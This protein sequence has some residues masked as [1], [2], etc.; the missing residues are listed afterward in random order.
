MLSHFSFPLALAQLYSGDHL[1]A[2]K[3]VEQLFRKSFTTL[4]DLVRPLTLG[5]GQKYANS[6]Y[7]S[8][9]ACQRCT[10]ICPVVR[11]FDNPAEALGMLPHQIIFSL[12]IGKID[13]AMGAQMI[14]SCSTC[15][16][17]QEHC[18]NQ[19]ELCDIFY[20]L[21]NAAIAKIEEGGRS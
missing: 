18:P 1:K 12:G 6:S 13:L 19:V 7:Q 17:C 4:A 11:S 21:K 8:C 20:G 2:L 9:Y 5:K 3:K 15:Y 14:W 16:L 10:N